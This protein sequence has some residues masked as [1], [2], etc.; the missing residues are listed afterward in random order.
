MSEKITPWNLFFS[1]PSLK[2][3]GAKKIVKEKI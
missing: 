1:D 2:K 3:Y